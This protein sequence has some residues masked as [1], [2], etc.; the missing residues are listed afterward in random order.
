[1]S[2]TINYSYFISLGLIRDLEILASDNNCVL[3]VRNYEYDQQLYISD[4]YTPLFGGQCL[5]LY[6]NP[7][8]WAESLNVQDN[9]LFIK[10]LTLKRTLI[11]P[12]YTA[13][14]S[15]KHPNGEVRWFQDRSVQLA[16]SNQHKKI[17]AGCALYVPNRERID[18][19][20]QS[21]SEQLDLLI[22][23]YIQILIT[24]Y[25]P[26]EEKTANTFNN[27]LLFKKL[28][29]REKEI[30]ALFIQGNTIAQVAHLIHL[31]P[32]TI[33]GYLTNLKA[34]LLCKS[35]SDLIMKAIENGWMTINL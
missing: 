19:D 26:H 25:Q 13:V 3:W 22:I 1:M 6:K 10:E 32:R 29:K 9:D 8:S 4:T 28:S 5:S 34:K 11:S 27:N 17:I 16:V 21:I 20:Q 24:L 30:F 18:S 15:I 35:K 2:T 23:K 33:E 14:F 12:D 31:S 7:D